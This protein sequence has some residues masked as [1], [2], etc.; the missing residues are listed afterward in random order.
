[1]R[2]PMVPVMLAYDAAGT[3]PTAVLLH[4]AVCDRRM[5]DPQWPVLAEVGYRVMR[6][7]FRGFGST[8][9]PA[10]PAVPAIPLGPLGRWAIGP[11]GPLGRWAV[12]AVG[13]V[14]ATGAAQ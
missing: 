8:P 14:E 9:V 5:W 7:E 12:G 2:M 1:V 4:S 3:G 11:L 10:V 6:C 13:A